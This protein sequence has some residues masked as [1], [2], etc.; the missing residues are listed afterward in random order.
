[1]SLKTDQSWAA[2][3]LGIL[4]SDLTFF[5]G[6]G[7]GEGWEVQTLLVSAARP[8]EQRF[9]SVCPTVDQDGT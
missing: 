1:M 7:G 2:F 8:N 6:G 9:L 3:E 4:R 5:L